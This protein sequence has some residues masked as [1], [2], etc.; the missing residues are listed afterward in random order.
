[1]TPTPVII[2]EVMS[3]HTKKAI[4]SAMVTGQTPGSGGFFGGSTVQ[5]DCAD[6]GA[7]FEV[8]VAMRFFH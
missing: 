3:P 4:P 2:S 6:G 8:S 1:M 7:G 5:S